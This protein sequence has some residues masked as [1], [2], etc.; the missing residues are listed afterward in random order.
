VRRALGLL[1]LTAGG[2][3][4]IAAGGLPRSPL[5]LWNVTASAPKGLWRIA[6]GRSANLGEWVV[7]RPPPALARWLDGRGYLPE[8]ALLVKR[9]GAG[10]GQVVCRRGSVVRVDGVVA[11]WARAADA[12]GR[13][14]PAWTGC[15]RLT[16]GEVLLLGAA[17][18]SLDG[19]YL[20]PIPA[21][22]VV[23]RARLVWR[24]R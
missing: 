19:R 4:L 13:P 14:L 18:D 5:W 11:A 20:G 16:A 6:P 1:A 3:A 23:G 8:G 22:A 9:V 10:P 15:V 21:A 2:W 24:D 17:P 12:A 7:A